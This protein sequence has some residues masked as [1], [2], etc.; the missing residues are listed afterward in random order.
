MNGFCKGPDG[1]H[2]RLCRV[3]CMARFRLWCESSHR[4]EL[5]EGAWLDVVPRPACA[6][7]CFSP[8]AY[9]SPT[10][11]SPH[12][13]RPNQTQGLLWDLPAPQ[14]PYF[15]QRL[16]HVAPSPSQPKS[17]LS[18]KFYFEML[19]IRTL[20]IEKQELS[21]TGGCVSVF[22]GLLHTGVKLGHCT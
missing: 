4:G 17:K 18:A 20:R 3:C 19:C 21:E 16:A 13:V 1:K 2:L 6:H 12:E 11:I 9:G 14:S 22:L 15:Y 7:P 10:A 8:S 5:N